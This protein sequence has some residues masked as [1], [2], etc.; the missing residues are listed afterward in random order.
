MADTTFTAVDLSRLPAPDIVETLDFEAILADA[1]ARMKAQM[2]D[3]ESRDSDP[4]TKLLQAFAYFAHI[5]RQRINEAARAVM[6]AF[7]TG[8]DL[9][10]IAALFGITRFVVT[11]ADDAV[12]IS[13]IVE[14]DT[15]FRRRMVLAPEGY[16]VAGPEGAYIFHALSADADILDASAISPLPGEV[17]VTIMS[18]TGNGSAPAPLVA[19]VSDYLTAQTRRPL[20]DAVS[21]QSAAIVDYAVIATLTT[22]SGPDGELVLAT[23]RARLDAYVASCHRLGRDVTRS[24]IFA[25]L[26]A[27][28]VQNVQLASPAADVGISRQQAPWC[29]GITLTRAGVGE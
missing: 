13:A 4:A 21:V 19:K 25:A 11:P 26:H 7:A 9:D 22:F 16:S 2:P 28:G 20:T 3:F 29:G 5:L 27:E 15:D 10:N 23:A 24:G 8:A 1:I 12:G 14:S 18:R 17:L 6:P